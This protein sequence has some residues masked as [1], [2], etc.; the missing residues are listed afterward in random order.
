MAKANLVIGQSGGPTVVINQTLVGI[1]REAKK[2]ADSVLMGRNEANWLKIL[3]DF[4]RGI[5]K[6]FY[7]PLKYDKSFSYPPTEVKLPGF[8][9]TGAIQATRGCPYK[10]DF[11]PEANIPGGA[12]YYERSVDDV[13]NEIKKIPQK[14]IMFYD[15]SLT[16]N[17]IYSKNLFKKMIGLRKRFFCN[18]NSNI[19]A[20]DEELVRLSKKAGC[21]SWLVGFE[22]VNQKTIEEVGKTTN[23][24]DDYFQ[25]VKNIHNYRI[26][27]WVFRGCHVVGCC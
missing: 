25:A 19:L 5:I 16:I 3:D 14:I 23:K 15:N 27:I 11:C 20:N 17:P 4:E 10:C 18:G 22:S 7:K 2:H 1:I 24:V 9:L 21:I 12:Q 26:C 6:P 13:I 8:V